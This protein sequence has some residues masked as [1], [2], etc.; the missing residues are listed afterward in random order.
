VKLYE[1]TE[2]MRELQSLADTGELTVE[3]IADTMDSLECMFEKKAEAALMVR[4]GMLAEV[5]GID[6]EIARLE[7]L[8]AAP[9]ANAARIVQ[10]IKSNMLALDKDKA[11]LGLFK[12]T[13]RKATDKLGEID[14]SKV[15]NQFWNV[16][17][18]SMKLNK[19][20]LLAYVKVNGMEGVELTKSERSLTIK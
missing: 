17:P 11:D 3:M 14:E 10:Y 5:A 1:I 9:M 16:V 6:S 18:Q 19:L 7:A 8:K 15:P 12:L 4:Q 13:L 20:A 2:E